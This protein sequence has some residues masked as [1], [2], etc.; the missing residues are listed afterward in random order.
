LAIADIR[1]KKQ[2]K[3]KTKNI[4]TQQFVRLLSK[5]RQHTTIR[6]KNQQV[7]CVENLWK[8]MGKMWIKP[9]N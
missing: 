5:K 3:M 7:S 6:V 1:E 9:E 2:E 8:N 4:F